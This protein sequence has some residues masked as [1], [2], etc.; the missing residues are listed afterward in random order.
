MNTE[1]INIQVQ[2]QTEQAQK[3]ID[4]L[5]GSIGDLM[6]SI[7]QL[8]TAITKN[9]ES[10]DKLDKSIS[11]LDK[12]VQSNTKTMSGMKTALNDLVP[13][14]GAA[15]NGAISLGEELWSLAA[16]PIVAT[17]MVIVA[18]CEL[19]F[20]A[21]TDN[22]GASDKLAQVWSG[23][24]IVL[25]NLKEAIYAAVRGFIDAQEAVAKFWSGDWKGAGEKMKEAFTEGK[26]A[27]DKTT[28]AFNGSAKA[29]EGITAAQQ[30]NDRA[31][32]VFVNTEKDLQAKLAKSRE[33]LM[34]TTASIQDK[35]KALKESQS[36]E[37]QIAG[38]KTKY[39]QKDFDLQKQRLQL[40]GIEAKTQDDI[41]KLIQTHMINGKQLS[42]DQY[43]ALLKLNT[44]NGVVIDTTTEQANIDLKIN[45]QK[46]KLQAEEQSDAKKAVE[47][48]KK[49]KEARKKALEEEL[50]EI[51]NKDEITVLSAKE[52][53][54]EEL[55]AK[56]KEL[57]DEKA[58][59]DKHWKELGMSK[60]DYE[61]KIA[62][63]N[64]K[65]EKDQETFRKKKEK[66][67][68]TDIKA[69]DELA[70]I[71]AKNDDERL[72]AKLKKLEDEKKEELTN[73][74]LTAA[75]KLLIEANYEK[76]K[77][78]IIEDDTKQRNELL[79]KKDEDNIKTI[80]DQEDVLKKEVGNSIDKT[81]KLKQLAQD[82]HDAKLKLLQDEYKATLAI[83]TAKG[84]DTSALTAKY[85]A[86][87]LANDA[88]TADKKR[89]IDKSYT[90][91]KISE[92]KSVGDAASALTDLLGKN[93]EAGKAIAIA[94]ATMDTYGAA[95]KALNDKYA[96]GVPGVVMKVAAVTQAIAMGLANVKKISET[97]TPGGSSGGGS[98]TTPSI[99]QFAAPQMF[100]LG[101]QKITNPK[102]YANQ[103]T[104]VLES[105][106]SASQ[107]RVKTIEHSSILGG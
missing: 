54:E 36:L 80:K 25:V 77:K 69:T 72:A 87:Q 3:N 46:K 73:E 14:F 104:Y 76:D 49:R 10:T 96:P 59:Y 32:A 5:Q 88:D 9:V 53:S 92:M 21:F 62:E 51:K 16:N 39:A 18:A 44:L 33:I 38:E 2:A 102:D 43:N 99:T 35:Q 67:D 75:Q 84:E 103:R 68:L 91:F 26:E 40:L 23:I 4:G 58:Y 65:K 41:N 97:K 70:I 29:M 95:N 12:S 11:K 66:D 50:K 71:N 37:N 81:N 64:K 98:S 17:F 93:T 31:K 89:N 34:D 78:K 52:G 101:G 56:K 28:A 100:G 82:E 48:A 55:K 22:V 57:D 107:N 24:Q 7:S 63:I 47:E 42:D 106:I 94:Q 86:D 45:K 90:D 19:I 15:A 105:D 27:V 85:N 61:L 20:K 83:M 79:K 13:G 60:V 6:T 74:N 8:T 30:E 1:N